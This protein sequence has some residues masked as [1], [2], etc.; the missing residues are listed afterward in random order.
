MRAGR[1]LIALMM[2]IGIAGIGAKIYSRFLY[3]S[4]LL[5]LGSL[6]WTRWVVSGLRLQR[7]SRVQ[8]ANVGDIFEEYFEVV[9]GS[10]IL[11]AWIE[12]L[13]QSAIPFASGSR[14]LTLVTGHQKRTYLART[15]LTRRGAFSL[16]PTRLSAGDPFGLFRSSKEIPAIQKLVVLPML[17]EIGSFLF[18]PGLLPGG[19]VIRR[20]SSDIT[21]HAA[22]VREYI[23]GDARKRIH[24]PTSVRRNQ[25]M[26]KEFEQD[27]QAEVWLY[28][29]SQKDVHFEKEHQYD[30]V[31][32]E[33]MLF[34]R[35]PKFH[36]PPSTLEY[37]ISITASL[38][39]YFIAQR[40]SVG[41]VS[42]G[43]AFTV[44]HAERSERQEAKILET[45]AFVEANGELSIAA[46]VAAQASQL[47]QGSS[48][49]LVTPT[50]RPDLLLAVDDLQRRYLRPVVVLLDAETFGG[51]S[52]TDK[53]I[54]SLRERRVP[55]CL[56]ACNADLAQALAELP[57][58]IT[59][60]DMRTWQ[61]PVLSH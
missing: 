46:L 42:A 9:N 60:Q 6:I 38:A 35:R 45:L 33:S 19:Q 51:Q 37:S 53:L 15:W 40:R 13:N 24:W 23:H 4:I 54:R 57:S 31:P 55:V 12:I 14:L 48:A 21:P 41:Y 59:S 34:G 56:I 39:H 61:S 26:V 29:D 16:G 27:P 32:V 2:V 43:Q 28:L 44:H 25:L 17:F 22:G 3:L 50:T 1:I 5:G 49:I 30:E 20:K 58:S 10:R 8:R 7:N 47:P 11:A 52:G 18:P 36:L